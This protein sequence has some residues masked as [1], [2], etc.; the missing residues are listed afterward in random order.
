MKEN[1]N[2][3]EKPIQQEQENCQENRRPVF[4]DK[5]PLG[6]AFFVFFLNRITRR[7]FEATAKDMVHLLRKC[8]NMVQRAAGLICRFAMKTPMYAETYTKLCVFIIAKL[9]K[10]VARAFRVH[11]IKECQ[12]HFEDWEGAPTPRAHSAQ[13]ITSQEDPEREEKKAQR[14]EEYKALLLFI[15]HL[16]LEGLLPAKRIAACAQTLLA[17][18]DETASWAVLQLLQVA[19]ERLERS[20]LGS[21]VGAKVLN[22]I[23]ASVRDVVDRR[24]TCNRLRFLFMDL[25]ELQESCWQK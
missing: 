7:R 4:V 24:I 14:R 3:I 2:D 1:E 10:Q 9:D 16:F 20:S 17:K 25:L 15:A 11:L 23:F 21:P 8:P 22:D 12:H 5:D 18:G 13:V 6:A 19:G